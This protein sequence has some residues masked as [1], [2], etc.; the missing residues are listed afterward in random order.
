[1]TVGESDLPGP[2]NNSATATAKSAYS[3]FATVTSGANATL[4]L[5]SNPT[6]QVTRQTSVAS[7]T[8]GQRV[9]YTFTVTNRG[10]VTLSNLSASDTLLGSIVL[11]NNML[12]PNQSTTG[13]KSYV[14]TEANLPGPLADI[15]SVSGLASG[16][17]GVVTAG[18]SGV[19]N[20][21]YNAAL[22]VE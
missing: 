7:A 18:T 12:L 19:V 2:L 4:A 14:V 13:T 20:L 9:Y 8:I 17:G 15:F 5:T 1:F 3:P 10:D 16:G 6:L 11:G 21:T 22:Q